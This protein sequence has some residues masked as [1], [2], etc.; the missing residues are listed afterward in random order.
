MTGRAVVPTFAAPAT[1][2]QPLGRFDG[3]SSESWAKRT[4]LDKSCGDPY[5]AQIESG[6]R[7][8]GIHVYADLAKALRV[9]IEDLLEER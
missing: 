9:Q 6:V 8:G 3:A 5:L 4:I 2:N 7:T 1:E